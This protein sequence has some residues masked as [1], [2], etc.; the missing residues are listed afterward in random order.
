M[1]PLLSCS[2]VELSYSDDTLFSDL[3]FSFHKHDKLGLIGPNGA[4]KSTFLSILLK[5][6]QPDTGTVTHQ[7][8]LTV[9]SVQQSPGYPQEWSIREA[10]VNIIGNHQKNPP[11]ILDNQ[12]ESLRQE[13]SLKELDSSIASLSGGELKKVELAAAFLSQAEVVFFD[14]PTNHLDMQTVVWLEQKLKNCRF[15]WICISHDR[16][17]LNNTTNRMMEIS[18]LFANKYFIGTGSYKDFL[19]Q[20][21]N[22]LTEQENTQQTLTNQ[23]RKE[24]KWLSTS[25]RARTTKARYRIDQTL[26]MRKQLNEMRR[27][28][29]N[30]VDSID[31]IH[32][33]RKSKKLITLKDLGFGFTD[34]KILNNFNFDV[35]AGNKI[36]LLGLNG[37]GKSTFLKILAGLIQ[38]QEG[39]IK[40][41]LNLKVNYYDQERKILQTDDTVKGLLC[42]QGDSVVYDNRSIHISSWLRKFGFSFDKQDSVISRM[43]G[44]EKAKVFIAKLLLDSCDIILLDEPTNDL[45]IDTLE[46]LEESL[47]SFP[48]SFVLI[49][50][51]RYFMEKVC[52]R[53][54]GI[55]NSHG[56]DTYNTLKNWLV[57]LEEKLKKSK[58]KKSDSSAQEI[59]LK[60]KKK[61]SYKEQREFDQMEEKIQKLEEKLEKLK[62]ELMLPETLADRQKTEETSSEIGKIQSELDTSY[63]RWGILEAKQTDLSS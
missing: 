8:G 21:E 48:G 13:L 16:Y 39:S 27:R 35:C 5:K 28:T 43:S 30:K 51:D 32:T 49:S 40:K 7:R 55:N 29:V 12:I 46:I 45:D 53:Y 47:I 54:I 34:K 22:Y 60:S 11:Q 41:A 26:D 57:T 20:K 52:N 33:D 25:P 44:G 14:E 17:F 38:P 6:I 59:K 36:G 62:E 42:S 24:E 58:G 23:L 10:I 56:F 19:V 18:P 63:E 9:H 50:H 31:F 3:S 15:A 4:G 37:T 2:Q 1:T 61:L